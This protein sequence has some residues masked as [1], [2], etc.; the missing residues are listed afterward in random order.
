M[1]EKILFQKISSVKQEKDTQA[2]T[3]RASGKALESA[4]PPPSPPQRTLAKLITS[5]VGCNQ[6][7]SN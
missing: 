1:A 4:T 5:I 6:S 3:S 2:E 7:L